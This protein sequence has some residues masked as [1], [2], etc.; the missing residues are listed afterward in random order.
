MQLQTSTEEGGMCTSPQSRERGVRPSSVDDGARPEAE[1]PVQSFLAS[2]TASE[3]RHLGSKTLR[4]LCENINCTVRVR[5]RTELTHIFPWHTAHTIPVLVT[6][7]GQA[8]LPFLDDIKSRGWILS[9][10][11][12]NAI[13]KSFG[14]GWKWADS[15][16][17]QANLNLGRTG[18][19]GTNNSQ[20]V[21]QRP[22]RVVSL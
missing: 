2:K 6:T 5:R 19:V 13:E 3:S 17:A 14:E 21:V 10:V 7:D 8:D 1:A 18:F 11:P 4:D 9:T 16:I 15:A 22:I 12:S 20:V